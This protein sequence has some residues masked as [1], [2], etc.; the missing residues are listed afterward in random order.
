M[1]TKYFGMFWD[2]HRR[3]APSIKRGFNWRTIIIVCGPLYV[4][5]GSW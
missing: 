1:S 5:L 3:R 4:R 2:E